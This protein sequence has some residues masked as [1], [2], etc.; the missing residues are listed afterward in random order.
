LSAA[1]LRVN[2]AFRIAVCPRFTDRLGN[3]IDCLIE[4]GD[5]DV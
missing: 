3:G 2:I 4:C 1:A 5:G